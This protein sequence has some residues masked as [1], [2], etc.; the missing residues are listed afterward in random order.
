MGKIARSA[1][2]LLA[3]FAETPERAKDALDVLANV[4]PSL[5]GQEDKVSCLERMF[6]DKVLNQSRF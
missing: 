6:K 1:L 2:W 3:Q 5:S 4:I